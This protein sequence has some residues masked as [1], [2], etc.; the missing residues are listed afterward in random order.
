[1]VQTEIPECRDWRTG[2]AIHCSAEW[3][4]RKNPRACAIYNVALRLSNGSKQ[5]FLSQPQVAKYF[6]WSLSAVKSAFRTL[7]E[8]GLF[9]LIHK[10]KG[11]DVRSRNFANVYEVINHADLSQKEEC[12]VKPEKGPRA[13]ND[14]RSKK[15]QVAV[16]EVPAFE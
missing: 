2:P 12:Y 3:H 5:F 4:L 1:M 8:S 13:K 9:V 10:G 7:Q 15:T 14:P 16:L 6:G 11:G